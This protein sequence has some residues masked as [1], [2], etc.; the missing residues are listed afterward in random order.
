VWHKELDYGRDQRE[1]SDRSKHSR[2][3]SGRSR[4]RRCTGEQAAAAVVRSEAT[5]KD[6]VTEGRKGRNMLG[7][8]L[9]V[10]SLQRSLPTLVQS[11]LLEL[12]V[13][14]LRLLFLLCRRAIHSLGVVGRV[15]L[16][17]NVCWHFHVN[18]LVAS[19]EEIKPELLR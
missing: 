3:H 2:W 13:V 17:G 12:L 19:G 15:G 4:K 8:A 7:I 16:G 18:L 11:H 1:R 6:V 9:D 10:A 14:R 5:S